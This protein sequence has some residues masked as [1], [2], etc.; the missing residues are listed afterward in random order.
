MKRPLLI[1]FFVVLFDQFVKFWIK[2]NMNLGEEINVTDK[3]YN[4]LFSPADEPVRNA[5][6]E[7]FILHFTENNGMAFG[8][9]FAGEYGKLILSLFRILAVFGIT[10]YIWTLVQKKANRGLIISISLI[11]AGA[12][13]NILDSAFYGILFSD[14]HSFYGAP[15][16]QLFPDAGGYAGILHGRV[17]D[18]L[19]F[20][21]I[22]TRFPEWFP[23]WGGED[24]LFF[25]P[26]FNIADSAITVG[27][28]MIVMFQR[29]YFAL[30]ETPEEQSNSTDDSGAESANTETT[31]DSFSSKPE[32]HPGPPEEPPPAAEAKQP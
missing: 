31:P 8:I 28:G 18:M 14:S 19:Y 20:P 21:V 10:W 17:V 9:E 27:V 3:L 26:V 23:F 5:W 25:R 6:G 15:H 11:L 24:F 4:W 29:R 30:P 13:G 22:E 12:L 32:E 16:A 2:L 1:V 7:W